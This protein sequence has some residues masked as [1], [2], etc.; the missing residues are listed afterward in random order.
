MRTG[1]RR[2]A[3]QGL[4]NT[5]VRLKAWLTVLACA[6]ISG[7]QVNHNRRGLRETIERT[8]PGVVFSFLRSGSPSQAV[9]CIG[10]QAGYLHNFGIMDKEF[11]H[12]SLLQPSAQCDHQPHTQK[13]TDRTGNRRITTADNR[14][15]RITRYCAEGS[16]TSDYRVCPHQS[17][18]GLPAAS[19]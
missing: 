7:P 19:S 18:L 4:G 8:I 9:A 3:P 14:S 1:R 13:T 10:M 6:A 12:C 5:S 15:E 11:R 16:G 17:L 2:P